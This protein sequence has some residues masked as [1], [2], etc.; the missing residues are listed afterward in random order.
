MLS[1][2]NMG[3]FRGALLAILFVSVDAWAQLEPGSDTKT[4]NSFRHSQKCFQASNQS[5]NWPKGLLCAKES[6]KLGR[7]IFPSNDKNIAS[8]THNY[9]LM[10]AKNAE[11]TAS[12]AQLKNAVDLYKKIHGRHSSNV[13]WAL[14]DLA[15]IELQAG[16][17]SAYRTYGNALKILSKDSNLPSLQYAQLAL[18]SG[19]SLS[20]TALNS[21][22]LTAAT[23][24]AKDAYQIYSQELDEGHSTKHLAAFVLGKLKY[25]GKNYSEA[26]ALLQEATLTPATATYAHGFLA[27]IYETLGES[28]A[29]ARH[30]KALGKNSAHKELQKY[31]PV[32]VLSPKYPRYALSRG[33][34]GYA[35]VEVVI[36]TDG[37]VRNPT[38]VKEEPNDWGFGKAAIKAAKQLKYAP[39]IIDGEAQEVDGVRY[40]YTFKMS[41]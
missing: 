14:L 1:H 30:N 32:F 3:H 8:L 12:I 29:A 21:K 38:I 24:M 15:D 2:Q 10:L 18:K 16:L 7:T 35:I 39:E 27:N 6:L 17:D 36:N 19:L 40:K 25:L 41:K 4:L 37:T 13:A 28:D 11:V 5:Q 33:K 20:G 22:S 26:K 34:E 23:K 31:H 9:G